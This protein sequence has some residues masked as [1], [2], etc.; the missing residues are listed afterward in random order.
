MTT[1]NVT[2]RGNGTY[3]ISVGMI[4]WYDNLKKEE[5]FDYM[6]KTS[7]ELNEYGTEHKFE[8]KF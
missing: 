1:V 2:K 4:I 5:V 6:G 7:M 8:F 3:R